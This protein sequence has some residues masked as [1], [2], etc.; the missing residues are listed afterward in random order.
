MRIALS[1]LIAILTFFPQMLFAQNGFNLGDIEKALEKAQKAMEEIQHPGQQPGLNRVVSGII[2]ISD[3]SRPWYFKMD[4]FNAAACSRIFVQVNNQR[5]RFL[6]EFLGP[7]P[8]TGAPIRIDG[9]RPG[10]RVKF[11]VKTHWHDR[12]YGPVDSGNNRFFSVTQKG[13]NLYYF[14]F[15]DAAGYDMA[16][17]D[18][19][20]YFYQE[21]YGPAPNR[22]VWI[23][24]FQALKTP[25]GILLKGTVHVSAT[26]LVQSRIDIRDNSWRTYRIINLD[27][28]AQTVGDHN[29]EY[30]LTDR[31][32]APM[33]TAILQV[34][35]QGEKDSRLRALKRCIKEGQGLPSAMPPSKAAPLIYY[36]FDDCQAR[37]KS[38]HQLNG[39]IYGS[40]KCIGGLQVRSL[41]FNS[42]D[43]NNGCGRP[44]GDF[45]ALPGLGA[46]FDR[47]LTVCAWAKFDSP[48]SYEKILDL[49][50]GPGEQWG[51]NVVFGRLG[52][53]NEIE[54]ESWINADG[55]LNRSTGRLSYPGIVNGE[56]RYYCAT[57]DNATRR[58]RLYINGQLKAEK[59]GNPVTNVPRSRNFIAHSNWCYNDPDFKGAIDEFKLYN[60]ALSP[61][62]IKELYSKGGYR[63]INTAPATAF[64]S[65][66]KNP[67]VFTGTI[68]FI[69]PGTSRLPDFTKL[70]PVGHIYTAVLNI[71]PRSF[72][73]GFPGVTNR[74][75][76]FAI[77]YK[78]QIYIQKPGLYTFSLL[79][80]DGSR[81]LID[82]RPVINNDGIHPPVEKRG[83]V[84]LS[85]GLH[86]IEVQYFQGPREQVALVLALVEG[87]RKVPFDIRKYAPVTMEEE[88]HQTKLTLG[89]GIL[90]DFNSYSLKPEAIRVLDKVYSLL[91]NTRFKKIIVEGY[92]DNIGSASYNLRLS[93]AR[94]QAVANYLIAKGVPRGKIKVV[95]YGEKRPKFPND[96]EEHRAK[97][98]RV[99]IKILKR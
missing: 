96:T 98:R 75:E 31:L 68:Y 9:L 19:A 57:I 24:D 53:S 48:R 29:F 89:S 27:F 50:N 26:G 34:N 4:W 49:G 88:N 56:W 8:P 67:F 71:S 70:N 76:W 80:D 94:A 66:H 60:R 22:F 37:D 77:D 5:P 1:F 58:M 45:V 95:G 85:R 38:G 65:T 41:Y 42:V 91:K 2:T 23:K 43:R 92:T 59:I 61:K 99:E 72:L 93:K 44:G 73:Q 52:T 83:S 36:S 12:I 11:L 28:M 6:V 20:F 7:H 69:P 63:G 79:S 10:D 62:E 64:G 15:E 74:F 86:N 55:T 39:V 46:V 18:G 51:Y 32:P 33:Y 13:A 21:G 30:N 14:Q 17:N 47:G 3:V 81:L 90:F 82:N 54:I 84:Y 25:S 40:P 97:N 35:F 87:N 78:G 16:K